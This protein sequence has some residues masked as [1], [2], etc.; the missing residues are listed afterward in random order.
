MAEKEA[1]QVAKR[2]ARDEAAAEMERQ[3]AKDAL[4]RQQKL[5]PKIELEVSK[6]APAKSDIFSSIFGTSAESKVEPSKPVQDIKGVY[7]WI[8]SLPMS[9]A[10]GLFTFPLG[11]IRFCAKQLQ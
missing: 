5:M 1:A 8:Y 7:F 2:R 11:N 3:K 10:D 9:P 6:P 4:E